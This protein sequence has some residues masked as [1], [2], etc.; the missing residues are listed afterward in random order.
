MS[1]SL[2]TIIARLISNGPHRSEVGHRE[3]TLAFAGLYIAS[4]TL[5]A[6]PLLVW[7]SA[8]SPYARYY[9]PAQ[10]LHRDIKSSLSGA[11]KE[12]KTAGIS[13]EEVT[14]IKGEGGEV[15][16]VSEKLSVGGRST[17]WLRFLEGQFKDFIRFERSEIGM[18]YSTP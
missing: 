16:A 10:S 4:T 1:Q 8:E 11:K 15:V 18:R 12:D 9:I 5:T 3:L 14:S 2:E 17:T 6:K 7:E 13:V